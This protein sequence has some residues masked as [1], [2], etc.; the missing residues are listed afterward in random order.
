MINIA[1]S[2]ALT[3]STWCGSRSICVHDVRHLHIHAEGTDMK[4]LQDRWTAK[5]WNP[6]LMSSALPSL[7]LRPQTSYIQQTITSLMDTSNMT[8]HKHRSDA[9]GVCGSVGCAVPKLCALLSRDARERESSGIA[10]LQCVWPVPC[11]YR[12]ASSNRE[13]PDTCRMLDSFQA[14]SAQLSAS[15]CKQ[16]RLSPPYQ[17]PWP[18]SS[19]QPGITENL[20]PIRRPQ[21]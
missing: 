10:R 16:L 6:S 4:T 19:K 18:V 7:L 9:S 1:E 13:L 12:A 11:V 21:N 15:Q 14:E 2:P 3:A 8:K 17:A 20:A 5:L